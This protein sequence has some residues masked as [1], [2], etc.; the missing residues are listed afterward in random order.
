MPE[1][2]PT[3]QGCRPATSVGGVLTKRGADLIT[4]V[5]LAEGFA[6]LLWPSMLPVVASLAGLRRRISMSA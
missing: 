3:A 4:D 5:L 1:F 6:I 2:E